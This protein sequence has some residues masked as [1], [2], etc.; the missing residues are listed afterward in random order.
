MHRSKNH[1]KDQC[2]GSSTHITSHRDHFS[3]N[4]SIMFARPCE[5]ELLSSAWCCSLL[6]VSELCCRCVFKDCFLYVFIR[7][8]YQ[9]GFWLD[10]FTHSASIVLLICRGNCAC[11][12]EQSILEQQCWCGNNHCS[13][14]RQSVPPALQNEKSCK[15]CGRLSWEWPCLLSGS[16][17]PT[18]THQVI[19]IWTRMDA[20]NG[21]L[22]PCVFCRAV[23]YFSARPTVC[24]LRT[25]IAYG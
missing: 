6:T 3:P 10:R 22:F 20:Y 5:I 24:N 25:L 17:F 12:F 18:A 9:I 1:S 8:W 2:T 23:A 13:L 15:G 14:L 11:K 16:M 19:F 21:I 4:H 7:M